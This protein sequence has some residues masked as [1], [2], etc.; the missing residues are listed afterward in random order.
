MSK[1]QN[2]NT[3]LQDI[4]NTINTLPEFGSGGID[5]SDATAA[6]EDIMLN[7]T[8]YANGKK[9]TGTFTID[10]EIETANNLINDIDIVL[11]N[12]FLGKNYELGIK[13]GKQAEYDAFWD[14]FQDY[15]NRVNYER[16]FCGFTNETFKPKYDIKPTHLYGLFWGCQMDIDLAARLEEL[17]VILDLSNGG[18]GAGI[19]YIFGSSKFTRIGKVDTRKFNN[20]AQTFQ[21]CSNLVTIDKIVLKEDGSQTFTSTFAGCWNLENLLF[22]GKIGQDIIFNNCTKLSDESLTNI[23]NALYDYSG[24]STTKTLTLGATLLNR[25]SNETKVIATEKGWTLV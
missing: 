19:N 23:I 25:L 11:N 7:K 10:E 18:S 22:E 14:S 17:G 16:A 5:T 4:L 8:A 15:G 1:I 6:S 9:I 20:L 13:E 3:S 12:K 24:T 2:N 21:T